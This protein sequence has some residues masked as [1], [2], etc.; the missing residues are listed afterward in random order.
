[1][2]TVFTPVDLARKRRALVIWQSITQPPL[3][4]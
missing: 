1:M 4:A 3:P 2:S